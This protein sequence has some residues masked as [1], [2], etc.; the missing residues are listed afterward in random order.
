[1]SLVRDVGLWSALDI[2]GAPGC[3]GPGRTEGAPRGMAEPGKTRLETWKEV[4]TFFGKDERTVK[5]W[6]AERGMPVHRLPGA[7]RS[8]IHA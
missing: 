4:A 8:R 2:E 3:D 6:E 7:A 5:R 1:M